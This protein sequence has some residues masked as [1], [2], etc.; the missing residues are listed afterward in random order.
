MCP[1]RLSYLSFK[2]TEMEDY[3][4]MDKYWNHTLN[5]KFEYSTKNGNENINFDD[6]KFQTISVF[7][8]KKQ[9]G[10]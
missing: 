9:I 10:I 6:T 8:D 5:F 1:S 3:F 2:E 4:R 7:G